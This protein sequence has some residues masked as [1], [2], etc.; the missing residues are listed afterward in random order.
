MANIQRN[1][2]YCGTNYHPHDWNRDR[3]E[4]DINLMKDAGFDIV[5]LGHLCWDSFEID[6]GVYDFEWFDDI[7]KMFY[8]NGIKVLLDI[9]TRPAPLWV[10]KKCP[11]CDIHNT[12]GVRVDALRRYM[13]DVSDDG[14]QKYAYRFTEIMSKRYADHPAIIAFGICNEIGCGYTSYSN[15]AKRRF[16]KWLKNKYKTIDNL[17]KAWST[18]RWSR[19]QKSFDD[20]PLQKNSVEMGSPE[21][22]L[23]MRRFISQ[24]VSDYIIKLAQIISENAGN[25]PHSSNHCSEHSEVGFDYLKNYDKFVDYPGIGFYPG[26]DS[27]AKV[28][29]IWILFVLQMRLAET[30]KPMWCLEFQTGTFGGYSGDYGTIRMY[31]LLCLLYRTQMNLAW[32]FRSMCSGEEQYLYGLVD[33]DGIPSKKYEEYKEISDIYHKL[34]DYDFPYLPKPE[35]AIAYNFENNVIYTYAT[36]Y[37]KCPYNKQAVAAFEALYD[38]NLDCNI[39]DL[40]NFN[41]EYKLIILPGYAQMDEKSAKAIVNFVENGGTVL[42]TGYSAKVNENNKVFDTP[43]P[44]RLSD[45]FGIRVA[46]FHR[47]SKHVPSMFENNY[48]T[49]E[50]NKILSLEIYNDNSKIIVSDVDYYETIQLKTAKEI[51]KFKHN[52]N[53]AVSCNIFGKGKAYYLATE[54]NKAILSW[55]L[56]QIYKDIGLLPIKDYPKEIKSRKINYNSV[57]LVNTSKKDIEVSLGKKAYAVLSNKDIDDKIN[58]SA[59]NGEL[60][61]FK[62]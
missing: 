33:H 56:N 16:Q 31:S 40:S 62:I 23:D 14:F 35:I 8:I 2:L 52:D 54:S 1:K 7:L 13:E 12:D 30:N 44:G 11:S 34:Q 61:V 17:N 57:F 5:R 47:T 9:S 49:E 26:T 22:Y 55:L 41:M 25:V 27:D 6:D 48:S 50:R 32:T 21:A 19:R 58:I 36:D 42:M 15:E 24:G 46:G 29:L 60:V 37:Y 53:C 39:I 59:L 45:V 28:D 38:D 51:A 43:H 10:H 3:W 18:Q 4:I 20:I